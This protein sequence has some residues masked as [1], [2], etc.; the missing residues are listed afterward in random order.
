MKWD[1]FGTRQPWKV[2]QPLQM[3]WSHVQGEENK[4]FSIYL[5]N[6]VDYPPETIL[7]CRYVR[8][9]DNEVTIPAL[10]H[11]NIKY[12]CNWRLWATAVNGPETIYAETDKFCIEE[13]HPRSA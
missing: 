7:L 4:Y 2:T 9:G 10:G 5:T 8:M 6:R 12:N 3:G 13:G 1:D 11:M